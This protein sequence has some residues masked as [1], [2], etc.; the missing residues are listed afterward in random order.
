MSS[1]EPDDSQANDA[2]V[3]TLADPATTDT[4]LDE[5]PREPAGREPRNAATLAALV[6]GMMAAAVYRKGG[7]YPADAFGVALVSGIVAVVA[8]VRFKDRVSATVSL[9]IGGLALWWLIRSVLAHHPAAFFPLGAVL[10]GF[11]GAF[12]VVKALNDR[13]RGR[14]A[15]AVVI[16]SAVTATVGLVG[17]LWRIRPLAQHAGGFWQLSTPLTHPAGAAG[18]FAVAL[19]LALGLDL[20]APVAR[21]ALCLMLAAV[22]GTQSHWVLLAL[23]CGAFFVPLER[24]RQAAW[25][26]AMGVGA[27]V[28]VLASA[29]SHLGSW[30]AALALGAAASRPRSASARATARRGSA[31]RPR[32][33][34]WCSWPGGQRSRSCTR[35]ASGRRPN[36]STRARPWRG[37]LRLGPGDPPS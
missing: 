35:P 14:V 23:A 29:S 30:P 19:L 16:V 2:G 18:M 36:P 37:R 27:G 11:L 4:A 9:T 26:L 25:P 1:L 21:V 34:C 6:V 8:L 22:I 24:W 7:F 17:V 13:D 5:P 3:L 15:L 20:D 10:I 33:C 31:W 28:V 32:S 12:V